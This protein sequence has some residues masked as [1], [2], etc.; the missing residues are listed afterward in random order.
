L[1]RKVAENIKLKILFNDYFEDGIIPTLKGKEYSDN[2]NS[3]KVLKSQTLPY[4]YDVHHFCFLSNFSAKQ[5]LFFLKN[6]EKFYVTFSIPKKSGGFREI[7]APSKQ[8]KLIQQWILNKILYKISIG[9]YVHGFVPKRSILTNA[10]NHVNQNLVLG[11]D[12]KDFFPSVDIKR[13]TEI[14]LCVGY[15]QK[16][17]S[18]LAELCT[19]EGKLPQGAPTSPMLANLA[20]KELDIAI[21]DYCKKRNFKYSRYADD[22]TISGSQKLAMYKQKIIGIVESNGFA[23]NEKK[24]RLHSKSSRQKVTGLVVNDKLSIGRE[25]KKKLRAIVHNILMK[26]PIVENR[27]NDP[28]FRERIFGYLGYAN[29]IAPEF[30]TPLIESIKNIDW[31]EY[32][33][34]IKEIKENEMNINHIKKM[35]KTI[36]IKFNDLGFFRMVV[37]FPEGVFSES[38]RNQLDNLQEKC[39]EHGIVACS[40]C[41]D[42]KKEIY[43]K[44]MKYVIGQYTGTTGGH[45]HGHEIYDMKSKTDLYGDSI[46][47]AFL[48]KSSTPKKESKTKNKA[49][50]TSNRRITAVD[51]SLFRQ[52]YECTKYENIDVI[53]IVTNSN[54]N[55]EL[56]ERLEQLIKKIN[57]A[58]DKEQLYC[59]IMRNE[60]KRIL[61]D[62]NKKTTNETGQYGNAFKNM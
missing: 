45:H 7:D 43:S 11:I 60:M 3:F 61:Y 6:K 33:E 18:F 16:T 1:T 50:T 58:D 40:D 13:V 59:L 47:V 42:I 37:E 51:D 38:F 46:T 28:F 9:D 41:L 5:I 2:F 17:A 4:I 56:S 62:F 10:S 8:M 24:T 21:D 20:V 19:Y 26:G 15:T 54:L 55:N 57:K 48:M 22:I 30:A 29:T 52:F 53:A 27:N 39:G 49:N 32:Y 14:F 25:N 12:I 23:V 44:C 36:L 34:S 31:S 35:N